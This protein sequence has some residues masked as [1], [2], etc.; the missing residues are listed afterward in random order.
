[1]PTPVFT[2]RLS[3]TEAAHLHQVASI[4]FEGKQGKTSE[5]IRTL[6]SAALSGDTTR[7]AEFLTRLQVKLTG[8]LQLELQAA[9]EREVRKRTGAKAPRKPRLKRKG[10]GGRRGRTT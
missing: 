5:F 1:M 4:Y 3:R 8:Q 7:L 2:F 9:V 6:L 10:K